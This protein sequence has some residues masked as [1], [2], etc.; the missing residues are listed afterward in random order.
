MDVDF[1]FVCDYADANGKVN[2]L[3]IG[4]DTIFAASAPTIA[5][6]YI[7]VQLHMDPAEARS[8]TV[9][10]RLADDEDRNVA[11]PLEL[12]GEQ[13]DSGLKTEIVTEPPPGESAS[14]RIITGVRSPIPRFGQYFVRVSAQGDEI[15]KIPFR[16][17]PLPAGVPGER[18]QP[19]PRTQRQ[20]PR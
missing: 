3:G 18:P 13:L 15:V 19:S 4:F 7:V 16:L 10:L 11:P 17:A 9:R 20:R 8:L 1:A 5:N 14:I 12:T 6:F 2:A